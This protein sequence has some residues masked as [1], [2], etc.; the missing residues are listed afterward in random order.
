[1][2]RM[3]ENVYR[4]YVVTLARLLWGCPSRY[5]LV[6]VAVLTREESVTEVE[7]EIIVFF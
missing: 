5:T 3:I 1:M 2:V 7:A 4:T 6:A